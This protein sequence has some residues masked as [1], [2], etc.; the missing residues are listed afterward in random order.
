MKF[1]ADRMLGRLS[2]WLRIL[3]YDTVSANSF[4]GLSN[5]EEDTYMLE[6]SGSEKRALLTKDAQLH[7][8]AKQKCAIPSLLVEGGDVIRQLNQ[9]REH[10]G[11]EFPEEPEAVRC[12]VCN[13]TL[14]VVS[15]DEILKSKEINQLRTK[16]VNIDK[17][18]HRYSHFYR[19]RLCSKI[20]WKGQHWQNMVYKTHRLTAGQ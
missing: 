4:S 17:F 2:S 8:R 16:G 7:I 13:G 18:S 12:S 20:F 6:L 9:V 14:E 11:L 1:L 19:C 15:I 5:A 10:Y 3:G